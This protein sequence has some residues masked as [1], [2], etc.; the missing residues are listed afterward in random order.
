CSIT[1][2]RVHIMVAHGHFVKSQPVDDEEVS[3]E[4]PFKLDLRDVSVRRKRGRVS[5]DTGSAKRVKMEEMDRM[6]TSD[7]EIFCLDV[8]TAE[9][10]DRAIEKTVTSV[11]WR[12]VDKIEKDELISMRRAKR[13]ADMDKLTIRG[14]SQQRMDDDDIIFVKAEG[15]SSMKNQ[16]VVGSVICNPPP[17]DDD[18]LEILLEVNKNPAQNLVAPRR[19]GR[20]GCS[21]LLRTAP[22]STTGRASSSY[23]SSI[24]G[25]YGGGGPTMSRQYSTGLMSSGAASSLFSSSS[26]N[27]SPPTGLREDSMMSS[28]LSL[29]PLYAIGD[30][31]RSPFF[32]SVSSSN[33]YITQGGL[34]GP[35]SLSRR[36]A[37]FEAGAYRP[38]EGG[39]D[40]M[41]GLGQPSYVACRP[42][43]STPASTSRGDAPTPMSPSND[44]DPTHH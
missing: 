10:S 1:G 19:G 36:A 14:D 17:V 13:R 12:M 2:L 4:R 32:P 11:V 6:E 20:F 37:A 40:A 33:S 18:D 8:A 38:M 24:N 34:M 3:N 22:M 16:T 23:S 7:D 27:G 29:S 9:R 28:S 5:D 26:L 35:P 30:G 44:P 39:G 42:R 25:F 15:E 43:S 21:S 31:M 41:R